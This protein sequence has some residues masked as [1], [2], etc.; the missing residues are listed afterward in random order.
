MTQKGV[1]GLQEVRDEYLAGNW[2][3]TDTTPPGPY[4]V[5]VMGYNDRGGLGL[6]DIIPRS[7]PVA[8]PGTQW[9]TVSAAYEGTM[10]IKTDN[11]A[12]VWGKNGNGQL[13]LNGLVDYSS[14]VQLTGTQWKNFEGGNY[15][16]LAT[17]TDNTLWSWGADIQGQGGWNADGVQRSSPTQLPGTQWDTEKFSTNRSGSMALKTDGTLWVWGWNLVGE[18][19]QNSQTYY[20]SPIQIPG[21]EWSSVSKA[22]RASFATKSDGTLWSWGGNMYGKLGHN[23]PSVNLSSPAQLPGTQ[24]ADLPRSNSYVPFALKT[25][26]TLWAI[27]GYQQSFGRGGFNSTQDNSSPIQVSGTQ[28]DSFSGSYYVSGATKSDG[29]LWLWGANQLSV[30]KGALG[31]NSNTP[32]AYSSPVQI[33]GTQWARYESG[34][35]TLSNSF[36]LENI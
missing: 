17:K 19:G 13:G 1:W 11:T 20:S 22:Y 33:P 35:Y 25:D 9:S 29:T 2:S 18:L 5:Y 12:W 26:G 32:A 14:P 24:W 31:Q 28:W 3:Y 21:T 4:R 27:G 23:G 36:L 34:G 30:S 7:S 16:F 15:H 8:I 6:N 10:G